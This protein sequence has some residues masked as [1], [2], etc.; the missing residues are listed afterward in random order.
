[1]S[2]WAENLEDRLQMFFKC[3]GGSLG[4]VLLA[5]PGETCSCCSRFWYVFL[6]SIFFGG[7]AFVETR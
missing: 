7:K 1:M 6:S 3:V 2:G 4:A 5:S